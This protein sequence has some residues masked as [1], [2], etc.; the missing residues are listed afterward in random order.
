MRSLTLAFIARVH[1]ALCTGTLV[2][3]E[4]N[5]QVDTQR[6]RPCKAGGVRWR[7]RERE[8][9]AFACIER[10][11]AFALA[12]VSAVECARVNWYTVGKIVRLICKG[13]P[14]LCEGVAQVCTCSLVYWYT[15][16]TQLNRALLSVSAQLNAAIWA[17]SPKPGLTLVHF[18]AQRK[19]FL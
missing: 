2:Q 4:Q 15:M 18:S 13:R 11:Q 19:H 16:S 9:N 8:R 6:E 12:P 7:E 17:P 10:H 3:Y 14:S 1:G 5:N